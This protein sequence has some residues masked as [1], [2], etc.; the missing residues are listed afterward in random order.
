VT[1]WRRSLAWTLAALGVLA[2]IVVVL[3]VVQARRPA[4]VPPELVPASWAEFRTSPGHDSHVGTGK[5][6]CRDCHDYAREGFKSPGSAPCAR[7]HAKE[8][9]HSHGDATQQTNCLACHVFAPDRQASTCMSCHA[10]AHGARVPAVVQHA[11]ES[12][13]SCHRVHEQPA[14]TEDCVDC[15]E[16]QRA[17]RHAAHAGSKGCL[18][19]HRAHVP[20]KEALATCA[21]CHTQPAGPRPAGHDSCTGCHQ[22]HDFGAGGES[23]CIRCHG[24][25]PTLAAA[26]AS[27]HAHADCTHCHEP[28]APGRAADSCR[29]CHANVAVTHGARTGCTE[30]HVPHASDPSLVA[31]ACTSCHT[32][33]GTTDTSAHAGGV[34]CPLFVE[35]SLCSRAWHDAQIAPSAEQA[36]APAG[37]AQCPSCH[38]THAGAPLPQA[39][40]A[41]CHAN[42]TGAP[43]GGVPGGCETCHRPHGPGGVPAPPSCRT[44]HASGSLPALHASPGHADCASCHDAHDPPRSDRATCTGSCHARERDHQPGA[45]VCTGCHV[46]RR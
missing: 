17:P 33:L 43:H 36:T 42:R 5:A 1:R 25:K 34:A 6:T 44:C 2:G 11:R 46:F 14:A 21:D 9:K 39:S 4:G 18:D 30:C 22:P 15:H 29:Q 20:A 28:H 40:C 12:C 13:A 35:A 27:E 26:R 24:L 19:C 31:A 10:E 16:R 37:H 41:S 3:V 32:N 45:I 7:C 8:A 38:E 23:A